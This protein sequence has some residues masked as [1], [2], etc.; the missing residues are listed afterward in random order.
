MSRRESVRTS[1]PRHAVSGA[2]L[3]VLAFTTLHNAV[4][5]IA[6]PPAPAAAPAPAA[7]PAPSPSPSPSPTP[8]G[9]I[10]NKLAAGDLLSA[11]SI[12]EVHRAQYGE[13]GGYLVGLSWLARGALLVG[14]LEKAKRYAAE[15]R[16]LCADRMAHDAHLETDHNLETAWEAIEVEA[17]RLERTGERVGATYVRRE[18]TRIRTSRAPLPAQQAPRPAD[19]AGQFRPELVVEDHV[20]PAPPTL[21]SLRG[22]P[23]LLF[24]WAEWCSDCKAQAAS[25]AKVRARHAARDY[26]SWR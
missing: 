20:G 22:K 3:A 12:L 6:Q 2:V 10:R 9:G 7:S 1:I 13:D 15:T 21:A 18:L 4:R 24:L 16:S 11:E 8:V 23:V 19:P 25:L 17:Q 14:D 26:R 5:A